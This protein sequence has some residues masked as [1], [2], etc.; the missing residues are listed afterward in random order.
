MGEK[1][2]NKNASE[3]AA[4]SGRR[5]KL[6]TG[7]ARRTSSNTK[8]S[9]PLLIK[10]RWQSIS[11]S[12]GLTFSGAIIINRL[13]L[14]HTCLTKQCPCGTGL[15]SPSEAIHG[16]SHL[17]RR[18]M[19]SSRIPSPRLP[20]NSSSSTRL[21]RTDPKS[22]PIVSWMA[23]ESLLRVQSSPRYRHLTCYPRLSNSHVPAGR[24]TRHLPANCTYYSSFFSHIHPEYIQDTRR[25]FCCPR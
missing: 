18:L 17:R 19:A 21:T 4:Q 15:S 22:Q 12:S 14:P 13:C 1:G 20:L 16:G 23:L 25:C 10:T 11:E 5:T 3:P 6:A 8:R 7:R 2:R 9:R 24:L